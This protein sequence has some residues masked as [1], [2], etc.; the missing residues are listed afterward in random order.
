MKLTTSVRLRW[1]LIKFYISRLWFVFTQTDKA[2]HILNVY[3]QR[4]TKLIELAEN[5]NGLCVRKF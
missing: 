2:V 4:G 5:A 3:E 1:L